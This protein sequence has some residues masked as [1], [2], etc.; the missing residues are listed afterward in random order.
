LFDDKLEGIFGTCVG[1]ENGMFVDFVGC[2]GILG[3]DLHCIDCK[4][5]FGMV[6]GLILVGMITY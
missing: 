4:W 2:L 3:I 6:F 1:V 5:V